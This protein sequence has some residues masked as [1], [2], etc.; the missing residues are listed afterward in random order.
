[1]CPTEPLENTNVRHTVPDNLIKTIY[2]YHTRSST[3]AEP[4]VWIR[5][6][7]Q[8]RVNGKTSRGIIA[9]NSVVLS[10]S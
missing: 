6:C 9:G 10:I 4:R 8:S 3:A 1:M 2:L 7:D 5:C